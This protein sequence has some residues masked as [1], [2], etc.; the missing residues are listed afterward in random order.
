MTNYL[1]GQQFQVGPSVATV[2]PDMDFET[3]SD[4]GFIFDGEKFVGATKNKRGLPLVGAAA[5]AEH[6]ST[7]VLSLA[8]DLKDGLGE[9]LWLP[10]MPPPADLFAHIQSGGLVEAHNSGFEFFIWFYVCQLRMGWPALPLEQLRCSMAKAKAYSLPGK[11]ETA[12][13]I[14]GATELK[15]ESGTA[16]MRKLSV[17]RKPTKANKSLR[18]TPELN[19]DQFQTLYKY[20]VQDIKAEAALSIRTPDL[21]PQ[22]LELWLLDQRINA[23]GVYIDPVGLQSCIAIFEQASDKYLNEL[24]HITGGAVQTA[25]EVQK[26]IGWLAAHSIYTHALDDDAVQTLLAR[27]D[28]PSHCR[29]VVEIREVMASS[30][31]KKLFAIKHRLNT[32]GRIRGLFA[33]CGADRTGRFAGRGPQPQNLPNSGPKVRQCDPVSGCGEYY[34]A[35]LPGC[36]SCGLAEHF[37]EP[38]SWDPDAVERALKSFEPQSLPLA[39]TLWKDPV[40]AVAGC[41]RGLFTAA[42][43]HDLIC[44]DYSAIEG[45]VAAMLSGEQWR[46]DVFRGHGKIYE[47][48]A[49][50]ITGV[51][52]EDMMRH[53]QETGEHHPTRKTIGKVSE[54]A[55]GFGGWIGAWKNFGADKFMDDDEI[56]KSILA[57]RDASPAI[58]EMWGGQH[59]KN[60]HR[61]EFTPE[62]YGLEGAVVSALLAP[63]QCFGYR[64]ITYGYSASDDVLY[65]KLL[66]GRYICYHKA[67]LTPHT[68]KNGMSEYEIT[69]EGT[70]DETNG[71]WS[72]MTTYSGKLFE[73]VVQATA[74]D[75]LTNAMLNLEKSG[76]PI[77]LHVHDEIVSE[78]PIGTGSV[79]EFEKIMGI[80]PEW[81]SDWPIRAA[82]GWRGK[83]YRKD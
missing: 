66:S 63:G 23:R 10:G 13:K 5:Y 52:F 46:I 71:K 40:A 50:K 70:S 11:L 47:M 65:C 9:R 22:E 41:L 54:L 32:D 27:N 55:S 75:I 12:A 59:R 68:A 25:S 73:N 60:P 74:R 42:P 49:S 21:Q 3:Y 16:T 1:S 83:R 45:V 7:E 17:P 77:V 14:V 53:K 78:V 37:S 38:K 33:Y 44:S 24:Q 43:G 80:M 64:G 36:P 57:W 29:R 8:Y 62:L 18:W 79:E 48:G 61:W 58:V 20:N 67:R 72:T 30:S 15:D 39:E 56:K 76:Y 34:H 69:Y 82:G 4:A 31:V 2:L 51:P 6:P 26:I 19:P 81:A 28:L 35:D